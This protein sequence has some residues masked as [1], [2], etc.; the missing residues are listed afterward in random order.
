M[1][2]VL[3]TLSIAFCSLFLK[4]QTDADVKAIHKNVSL[5]EQGWAEKDGKKYASSFA[6]THDFIV[7]NGY[8]FPNT[9]ALGTAEAHQRLF[10]G[11]FQLMDIKLK[12]DKVKFIRPDIAL[13]HV[14]GV[15]YDKGQPVPKD[16]GVLMSL[17][18]EK[19]SGKWEIISFHNLDL[20]TFQDETIKAHMPMPA[21]IMYASWYK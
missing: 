13:A 15:G 3:M 2:Q 4:A 11:R 18:L 19:K 16:P 20:E 1:K 12:V 14:L 5:M 17:L 9:S 6:E 10:D 21:Q 7:W 8:Y